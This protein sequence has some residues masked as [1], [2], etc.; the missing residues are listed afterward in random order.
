MWRAVLLVLLAAPA[1][2]DTVI[3]AHTLRAQSVIGADDL[4]SI[5]SAVPGALTDPT[6]A[7]GREARVAL[8]AGHPIQPGDIGPPALVDRNQLVSLAFHSGGLNILA[9]GRALARGGVGDAI[10]VMNTA[11]HSTVT[12][13]IAPDGTVVVRGT[14]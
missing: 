2:A 1:T 6:E 9:E 3:A 5:A 13:I 7:I 4:S 14:P 10:R 11:S 12:G 8:Y